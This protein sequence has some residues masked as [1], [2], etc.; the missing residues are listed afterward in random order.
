MGHRRVMHMWI[1]VN[2][3]FHLTTT[4]P[5]RLIYVNYEL[6]LD[7]PPKAGKQTDRYKKIYCEKDYLTPGVSPFELF[8]L[9]GNF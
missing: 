6:L 5:Y 8:F 4:K 2:R 9:L 3:L 7:P 1:I